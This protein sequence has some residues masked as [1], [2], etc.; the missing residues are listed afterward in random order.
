MPVRRLES[1]AIRDS[2]L[3]V[4]DQLDR[5]LGGPPVPQAAHSD[6]SITINTG[7]L[8]RPHDRWR[9][10]VYLVTR[11]GYSITLLQVFDQ[12]SILTT[13]SHRESS[14]VPLQS[15]TMINGP[16]VNGIA[17][18]ITSQVLES[19]D[20][21]VDGKRWEAIIRAIY[22]RTLCR[23]PDAE[24]IRL[25][26]GAWVDNR[27]SLV[28]EGKSRVEANRLAVVEVCHTLLNT[29]EFLYRE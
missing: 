24:E 21:P 22:R 10:S 9:R 23:D 5:S 8:K 7:G 11:R 28:A 12:P 27:A 29:S 13:C 26:R 16:F 2:L 25:C 6:G 1:E 3:A 15:L 19:S 14:A 20:G 4:A 17:S 18:R